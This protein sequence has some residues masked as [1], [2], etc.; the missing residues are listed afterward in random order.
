MKKSIFFITLITL[1]SS[2]S[3][4][5][6]TRTTALAHEKILPFLPFTDIELGSTPDFADDPKNWNWRRCLFGP[7]TFPR[8]AASI[9]IKLIVTGNS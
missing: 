3:K 8:P 5:K 7:F 1:L 6:E 9:R 4:R 2:C